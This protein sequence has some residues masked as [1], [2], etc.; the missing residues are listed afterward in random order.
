VADVERWQT[1]TRGRAKREKKLPAKR[2]ADEQAMMV[3][4]S[5]NTG[6]PRVANSPVHG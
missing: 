1:E 5:M 4:M 6:Q 3:S 2:V